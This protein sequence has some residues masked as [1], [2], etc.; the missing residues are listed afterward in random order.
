MK[1]DWAEAFSVV[2]TPCHLAAK[3]AGVSVGWLNEP[4][5]PIRSAGRDGF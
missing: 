5:F 1:W 2:V 3:A 4:P